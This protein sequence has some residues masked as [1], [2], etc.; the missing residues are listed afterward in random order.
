M[1]VFGFYDS[2]GRRGGK[3]LDFGVILKVRFIRL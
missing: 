2:G 1:R 3:N